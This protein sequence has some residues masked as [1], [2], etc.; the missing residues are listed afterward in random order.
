M[1]EGMGHFSPS[2]L[3]Q[4]AL[5][6]LSQNNAN[7]VAEHI[8][9]CDDCFTS[10]ML[11]REMRD[12]AALN[13]LPVSQPLKLNL[14]NIST[15]K[16]I[17]SVLGGLV[18][19]LGLRGD[20][21]LTHNY[22]P[23]LA[24]SHDPH[25]EIPDDEVVRTGDSPSSHLTD[26][27]SSTHHQGDLHHMATE[28]SGFTDA[29]TSY[30]LP[31]I[32]GTSSYIHQ[33]YPDTCAIQSQRLI[34]NQFGI[35][36]TEDQLRHEAAT[37]GFY[38]PGHGTSMDDLGKL[39]ES[40][41]V[42]VHRELNANVFNLTAELAQGHKVIV[43]VDCHQLWHEDS[44]WQSLLD[45]LGH[46]SANHALI[47][48][49]IDTSDPSHLKVIVT[50]PGTGDVAKEY[51]IQQFLNAWHTSDFSMVS[52]SE[53]APAHLPEMVNFDYHAGHVPMIGDAPYELAHQLSLEST[54]ADPA[55]L[56]HL[57]SLFLSVVEGGPDAA[58]ALDELHHHVEG[59]GHWDHTPT[60]HAYDVTEHDTANTAYPE[61]SAIH[62][63]D[64][65]HHESDSHDSSHHH[66]LG[67]Y[68]HDVDLDD[69]SADADIDDSGHHNSF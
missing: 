46:G 57:E 3:E 65:A 54:H 22:H 24:E 49:G 60:A 30:G 4:Y 38:T 66:D 45:R 26:G 37:K 44:M 17:L 29:A 6:Q 7:R 56:S 13:L 14:G 63:E 36:V 12:M 2:I 18:A 51:P 8:D 15:G 39:L 21:D 5:G 43:G 67:D 20:H 69:G 62:H 59:T 42:A 64:L 48:S 19:G 47:V 32:D 53:P 11:C 16:T 1:P 31:A 52:T 23:A 68:H 40:H 34:L 33:H 10:V 27:S 35:G 25:P 9:T 41:G 28:H 55:S 61:D 58:H 50:D